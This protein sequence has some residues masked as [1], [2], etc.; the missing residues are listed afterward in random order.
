[1][2]LD[3]IAIL[4]PQP[5]AGPPPDLRA[6]VA[7]ALGLTRPGP[8]D[9]FT[10]VVND[11]Q[12]HTRTRPVLKAICKAIGPRRIRVL[13]ATGT[14]AFSDDVKRK[15]EAE[16]REGM[17]F[18]DFAWHDCTGGQLRDIHHWRG[19]PWL[20][21]EACE[22]DHVLAIGSVEP[23][24][25][26]GFTGAH[27]TCTIGCA[28]RQ[29]IEANHAHA[30]DPNCR[31]ARLEGNPIYEGVVGMLRPLEARPE[32]GRGVSRRV[33]SVNLVQSGDR[34]LAAAG[35]DPIA[36]L[37]ELLPVA[38]EIFVR[39]I[40]APADALIVEVTGP[41]GRSFYQADKGIK[42]N[43]SAVRDGGALVLVAPCDERVGQDHFM[44]LLREAQ[45]YEQAAAIV[46]GRGYRLGDHKA[47]RL[48]RL[49]DPGGR[50]VRVFVVSEGLPAA[51]A[52]VLGLTKA[53]SVEGALAAAG[54]DPDR[55]RV[56][57]VPD[58]GNVC[59]TAEAACGRRDQ[60]PGNGEQGSGHQAANR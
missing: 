35:G 6:A 36:S 49:T 17:S 3:D 16:L 12:R 21:D 31:P 40:D 41:L 46:K 22:S 10:V 25:F 23:H 2:N 30:L 55:H 5:L 15:F 32:R 51:D 59:V 28:A 29:D 52:Q 43:E 47:V 27:K 7:A 33:A 11:P 20:V 45:T 42:N 56:F 38:E 44:A 4:A 19:H 9:P 1:M 54:I 58:A 39:R 50:N 60:G 57:R 34:I 8:K 13:V 24:Y 37:H 48:R 14:H 26:A 53:P 18:R